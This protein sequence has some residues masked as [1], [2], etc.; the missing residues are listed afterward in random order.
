MKK[1]LLLFLSIIL[2][3]SAYS[4]VSVSGRITDDKGVPLPGVNIVIKGTT[5]GTISGIDGM[6]SIETLPQD[7][8]IFSFVGYQNEEILVE[9]RTTI[10]VQLIPSIES[11]E[12]I[13][14]VGYGSQK[15]INI[16]GSVATVNSDQIVNVP[17][18]NIQNAL[19]GKLPGV[20]FINRSGE[21][22]YD[23]SQIRIRG[24]QNGPLIIVDGIETNFSRIDPNDIESVSVLKDGSASIY[25]ARAGN[26]VLLVTTKKGLNT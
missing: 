22:G 11:L 6:Y 25:G 19:A 13:V 8:L 17:V 3:F 10:D 7:Y 20:V 12:E 4:Q 9:N 23:D 1:L 24:F 14:V 2:A 26:G 16:T 21:P 5:A 15:K 18:A